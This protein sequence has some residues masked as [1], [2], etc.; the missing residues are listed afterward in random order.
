MD[1]MVIGIDLG[2]TNSEI[3]L[4]N[5]GK[6]EILKNTLGDEYTPSV[7]GISKGGNEEVGKKPYTRYFKDCTKDEWE[8]NKPEIKRSMGQSEKIYFPRIQKSY[9]PEEISSKILLNLKQNVARKNS[10]INANAAVITI[11]A[12]FDTT[13]CEATKRAGNLAGFEYVILLQEPIAAAISYGFSNAENENW[14]VYD[15]G[16]GTFDV[17]LIALKDGNLSVLGHSGDN[18]LGGKDI[19]NLII[20]K[21]ILPLISEKYGVNLDRSDDEY[22]I[23]FAKLKYASE[24]AKIALSSS[25]STSIEIDLEDYNI[26]ENL[27]ITNAELENILDELLNKTI[28][29]AKKTID[30]ANVSKVDK[31]ILVGGPTQLPFIRT[32]LEKELNIKVDTS[33][34]ALTAVASGACIYAT[35]QKIPEHL[36]AK[37][38][39]SNDAFEIELHYESLTSSDDELI[40]GIIPQLKNSDK[41]YFLRIQNDSNTF[42]SGEIKLKNGKFSANIALEPKCVNTFH[43]F[44][45]AND[46]TPLTLS[47]N[48]FTI[49]HGISI[50]GTP[51]PHSIGVGISKADYITG[52]LKQEYEI[53]FPK[54]SILPLEK[55][56]TF[57]SLKTIKKGD[58][59]NCLPITIYEGEFPM[60]DRNTE[61]CDLSISGENIKYTI[62]EGEDIEVTIKVNES[63]EVFVEAY[64][65]LINESFNARATTFAK[66]VSVIDL[67]RELSKE[68]ERVDKIKNLLSDEEK[69]EIESSAESISNSIHNSVNNNDERAKAQNQ[70]KALRAK[71]D[72]IEKSKD[73][74]V[75]KN[76][77]ERLVSDSQNLLE[78]VSDKSKKEQFTLQFKTLKNDAQKAI[79][80]NSATLLAKVN[81]RFKEFNAELF[82]EDDSMWIDM[83]NQL[84][85]LPL[86]A[87]DDRD[88]A[89]KL[90]AMGEDSLQDNDIER[91]RGICIALLQMLPEFRNRS[92]GDIAKNIGKIAGITL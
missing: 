82:G 13:Q 18:F 31:I 41:D 7:F 83:F 34:D 90:I 59:E 4:F 85:I 30:E 39:I 87:F 65:P 56:K 92:N 64:I 51:I 67:S 60:P 61:I 28:A 5:N 42:T 57:K 23:A 88:K 44:L 47:Q 89:K 66:E 72:A 26:Y 32:R 8:N 78:K 12:H 22:K 54:N 25:D 63:R 52:E 1:N 40:T 91:L 74:D 69:D 17:A 21:K 70:L 53:F 68:N 45:S 16:G 76:E 62:G 10:N 49:T 27:T 29:H 38:E 58:K 75:L 14:L 15:L 24:S 50:S 77:Y 71:I 36:K 11:P 37:K 46:G 2:T 55:T 20:D 73:I 9:L 79:T 80:Q 86:G 6:V 19:D 81:E 84:S 43:I 48:S 35:S 3:A 33:S